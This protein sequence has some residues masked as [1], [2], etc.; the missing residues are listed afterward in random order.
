MVDVEALDKDTGNK[1][2]VFLELGS[3]RYSEYR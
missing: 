2:Q 3:G 1:G